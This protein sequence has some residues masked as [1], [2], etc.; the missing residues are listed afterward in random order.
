MSS[1]WRTTRGLIGEII[2]CQLYAR[3]YER[4]TDDQLLG[5]FLSFGGARDRIGAVPSYPYGDRGGHI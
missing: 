1:Q 3:R 4:L 2:R 5:A